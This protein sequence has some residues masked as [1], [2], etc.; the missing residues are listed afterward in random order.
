MNWNFKIAFVSYLPRRYFI[1]WW[2]R[3]CMTHLWY[4]IHEMWHCLMMLLIFDLKNKIFHFLFIILPTL[5]IFF[6]K[7]FKCQN[8]WS[9]SGQLCKFN[10]LS[11]EKWITY[12]NV[13]LSNK[14]I[15]HCLT[16]IGRWI[17]SIIQSANIWSCLALAQCCVFCKIKKSP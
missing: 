13:G 2:H 17:F 14:C 1:W 16:P 6:I 12:P 4:V 5:C 8:L 10:H 7:I 11:Q 9:F 15:A 3:I